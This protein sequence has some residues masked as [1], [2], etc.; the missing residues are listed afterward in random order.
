MNPQNR[1][2]ARSATAACGPSTGLSQAREAH[3]HVSREETGHGSDPTWLTEARIGIVIHLYPAI[4][5]YQAGGRTV[6][7]SPLGQYYIH[8][9]F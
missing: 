1:V 8:I 7:L 3:E 2:W 6:P 4:S 9:I 5:W